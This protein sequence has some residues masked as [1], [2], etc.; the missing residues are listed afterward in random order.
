MSVRLYLSAV[1]SKCMFVH[2][3]GTYYGSPLEVQ[4]NDPFEAGTSVPTS[5]PWLCY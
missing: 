1:A 2:F 4:K 5:S 3:A